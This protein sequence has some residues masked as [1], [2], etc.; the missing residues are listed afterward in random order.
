M[1]N[2]QGVFHD[3]PSR[4]SSLAAGGGMKPCETCG[5]SYDKA[6]EVSIGG[7]THTFDSFACAIHMLAPRCN[8][9]KVAIIG[10]GMEA[11]GQYFCCSH[12]ARQAGI[13]ELADRAPDR[14]AA[15]P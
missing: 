1:L 2:Q 15:A 5:N 14:G 4:G 8:H 12:C 6:F 11:R 13:H 3:G 10:H 7:T 9:C